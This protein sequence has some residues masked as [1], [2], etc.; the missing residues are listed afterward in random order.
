MSSRASNQML[1]KGK[2]GGGGESVASKYTA[3]E[4]FLVIIR[5]SLPFSLE[6]DQ[7]RDHTR[8]KKK[9]TKG[10]GYF[11]GGVMKKRG[12]KKNTRKNLYS[13]GGRKGSGRSENLGKTDSGAGGHG[14][15]ENLSPHQH[16][17]EKESSG[18]TC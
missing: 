15:T 17:N 13:V 11:E 2:D 10:T 3:L 1:H 14:E 4:R 12:V 7:G 18:S 9:S 5:R 16:I 6:W 8:R